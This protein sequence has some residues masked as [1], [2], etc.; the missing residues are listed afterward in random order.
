MSN[1]NVLFSLQG[2]LR[3]GVRNPDGSIGALRWV[4]NVP[5]ATLALSTENTD[6]NESYSGQRLQIGRLK[7]A[8]TAALNY[9][10]DE[11]SSANLA[12]A[13]D[14]SVQS[15][16]S[17]TVTGEA[18]PAGLAVGDIVRLDHAFAT[19]LVITDSAGTPATLTA[20]THYRAVGHAG[21]A[22][23][24]LDLGAFTQPFNAA[25]SYPAIKNVVMFSQPGAE[26]YLQFDGI[27][28]ETNEPV[29]IDLWR[30]RH[31]PV[32]ELGL[33]NAEYGNLP[34]TAAVLYDRTRATDTALGGFGRMIQQAA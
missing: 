28:T 32:T 30:V 27:N 31:N 1:E 3:I 15:I 12:L 20:G 29:L 16:G 10:L 18:F 11:W 7:T 13:F 26:V 5:E 24:I 22:V 17:G 23:E 33:I 19:T 2:Y 4:G 14:A 9:T 6:R 34:M 21:A 8:T 25:Y